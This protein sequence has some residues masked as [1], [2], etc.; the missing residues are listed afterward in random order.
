MNGEIKPWNLKHERSSHLALS[1]IEQ[2]Q[3]LKSFPRVK[4]R[5]AAL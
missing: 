4:L 1:K 5:L 2:Y 3:Y